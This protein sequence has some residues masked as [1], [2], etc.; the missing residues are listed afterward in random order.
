MGG[1]ARARGARTRSSGAVERARAREGWRSGRARVRGEVGEAGTGRAAGRWAAAAGSA[2]RS[3]VRRSSSAAPWSAGR[4]REKRER[5]TAEYDTVTL[6]PLHATPP[7]GS[8]STSSMPSKLCASSSVTSA[9]ASSPSEKESA[10]RARKRTHEP[11]PA[12][13]PPSLAPLPPVRPRRAPSR[14]P[15]L[16]APLPL[17]ARPAR[18]AARL[19]LLALVPPRAAAPRARALVHQAPHVAPE[20]ER[21][22][23]ACKRVEP[24]QRVER[25]A[26]AGRVRR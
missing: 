26:G 21:L 23:Q 16:V 10:R 8:C 1:R 9:I 18:H 17:P 3:P 14:R 5:R 22:E 15:P 13:L 12:R 20:R 6:S 24:L 2:A 25:E 11:L 7:P 4:R 19:L